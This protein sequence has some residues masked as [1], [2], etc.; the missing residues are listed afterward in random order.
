M[1]EEMYRHELKFREVCVRDV[2][3][4]VLFLTERL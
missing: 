2:F 1:E 4:I 3:K